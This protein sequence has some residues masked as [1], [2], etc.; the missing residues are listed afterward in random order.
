MLL[1]QRLQV[2]HV[3]ILLH[4][5]H[6]A[7][8]IQLVEAQVQ[9]LKL[10]HAAQRI[11]QQLAKQYTH[12]AAVH[13]DKHCFFFRPAQQQLNERFLPRC[14]QVGALPSFY[15]DISPAIAP[16]LQEAVVVLVLFGCDAGAFAGAPVDFV[17]A[18]VL[19][20]RD[21]QFQ[22]AAYRLHAALERRGV[23]LIERD[24]FILL[25]KRFGLLPAQL[26]QG[27]I[28][29]TALHNALQ[30]IVRLPVAYDVNFLNTQNSAIFATLSNV[31]AKLAFI[32]YTQN[33]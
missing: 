25:E 17:Q 9:V 1:R 2:R 13:A 22:K 21:A 18:L 5:K 14:H 26:V 28:D 23:Y 15:A 11:M 20:V 24:I 3:T 31:N 8:I 12:R 6:I 32:A 16:G 33:G 30:I 27:R 29:A 10:V 19:L 4:H 7:R